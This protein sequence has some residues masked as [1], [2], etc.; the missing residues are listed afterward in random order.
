MIARLVEWFS[1]A[2]DPQDRDA[3]LGDL[4]E[5]GI[6]GAHALRDICSLWIR[7]QLTEW[8]RPAPWIALLTLVIPLGL[9]LGAISLWVADFSAPIFRAMNHWRGLDPFLFFFSITLD[10]QWLSPAMLASWSWS[11]GCAI[12]SVSRRAAP[13]NALL[14]AAA[15]IAGATAHWPLSLRVRNDIHYDPIFDLPFYGIVYPVI[16]QLLFVLLPALLGIRHG[17]GLRKLRP[18][19]RAFAAVAILLNLAAISI[20]IWAWLEFSSA[21]GQPGLWD[22]WLGIV[23]QLLA[24]WPAAYWLA[25]A[26]T[27][28]KALA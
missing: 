1:R 19:I 26:R 24:L 23:F 3:V 2:L 6:S 22:G 25:R 8:R 5:S 21:F 15:L 17:A 9:L 14:L 13:L 10:W 7:R 20:Q 12:G 16:V 18:Q 4:S 11:V 27:R 28:R